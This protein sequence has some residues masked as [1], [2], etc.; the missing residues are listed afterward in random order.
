M[1]KLFENSKSQGCH[2][3][4]V[5]FKINFK[6]GYLKINSA[7]TNVLTMDAG[8]CDPV[9]TDREHTMKSWSAFLRQ[10]NP[11]EVREFKE[12]I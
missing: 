10:T 5:R 3:S 8:C 1:N 2:W 4:V 9:R 11:F 6:V 7:S 12:F